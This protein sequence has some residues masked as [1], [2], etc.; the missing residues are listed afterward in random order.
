MTF[1]ALVFGEYRRKHRRDGRLVGEP[2][3]NPLQRK[4]SDPK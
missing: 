1:E 3:R 2:E 4:I